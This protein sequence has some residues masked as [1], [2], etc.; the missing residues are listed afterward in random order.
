[1]ALGESPVNS[2]RVLTRFQRPRF[3]SFRR[4]FVD[5]RQR[6]SRFRSARE[7]RRSKSALALLQKRIRALTLLGPNTTLPTLHYQPW[8]AT[9]GSRQSKNH[10][11]VNFAPPLAATVTAGHH[12]TRALSVPEGITLHLDCTILTRLG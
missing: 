9:L 6:V 10:A 2:Q 12:A 8:D 4:S 11:K 3:T 5:W 1:M 7:S